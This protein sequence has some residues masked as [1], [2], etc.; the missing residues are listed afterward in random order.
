MPVGQNWPVSSQ[1][2]KQS[3]RAGLPVNG[4]A[5]MATVW[6]YKV[7]SAAIYTDNFWVYIWKAKF[8]DGHNSMMALLLLSPSRYEMSESGGKH[9][10]GSILC[11]TWF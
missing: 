3:E 4:K 9:I 6:L 10:Q 1:P 11:L 8:S 7:V 2:E 5:D